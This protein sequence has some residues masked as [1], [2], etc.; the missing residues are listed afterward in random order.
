MSHWPR[1]KPTRLPNYNYSEAGGY[2]ITVCTEEKRC[3]LWDSNGISE[4]GILVQK[5][6]AHMADF[7]SHIA[8]DKY[9]VMPNHIHMILLVRHG[10]DAQGANAA[11]PKFVSAFK[12]FTNRNAG[13]T[14]WQRSY[15]DHVIRNEEDYLRIWQYIDSNPAKWCEDCYFEEI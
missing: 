4:T 15:H 3:I 5:Q 14:L 1:R 11:I 8:I 7:Y 13:Q 6:L 12:R 2:F 10:T 9:V